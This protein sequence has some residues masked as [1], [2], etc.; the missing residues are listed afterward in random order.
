MSLSR[1]TVGVALCFLLAMLGMPLLAQSS[2]AAVTAVS[3][4]QAVPGHTKLVPST[5]RTDTPIIDDGEIWDMEV[6]GSR[7]YIAGSFTSI[8]NKTG[9][10][11]PLA[12]RYLAAYDFTT[13]QV[14]RTFTPSFD[15]I[16]S[17]VDASPDGKALRRWPLQHRRRRR[18]QQG[19]PTQPHQRRPRSRIHVPWP[20]EQPRHRPGGDEHLALRRRPVL[21]DQQ[22]L[23][24]RTRGGR[25]DHRRRRHRLRQPALRWNRGR[26]RATVQDLVLTHDETKLLVVHTGRKIDGQDRLGSRTHR[27]RHQAAAPL[28][29][30]PLGRLPADRRRRPAHLRRRHLARRLATSWSAAAPVATGRRSAT[31]RSRSRSPAATSSSRCGSRAPST[32]STR[33]PSPRRPSTSAATSSGTSRRPRPDPWPGLDNVGYGTGQGLS[34][35]GL[36]DAGRPP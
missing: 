28:A 2:T 5:P 3:V 11:T 35:Y 33:W 12:Q 16:V 17:A 29:Y 24:D 1:R 34:G 14:V 25:R 20:D 36:G 10:T 15:G 19:R 18:P 8:R 21:P 26:W 13:G 22:R 4:R 31:R 27:H 32:A 30:A 7:V 23:D 6:I 9:N